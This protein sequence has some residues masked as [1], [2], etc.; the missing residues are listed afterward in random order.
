MK[1]LIF[2]F[3]LTLISVITKAQ[4]DQEGIK[5]SINQF[6][7]GMRNTDSTL[8]KAVIHENCT[9]RSVAKNKEGETVINEEKIQG[10][11]KSVGTKREG[12]KLDERLTSFD[13]KVDG[14]MGIA[15]TPYRFYVNDTFR[16]CGVNVFS[17]IKTKT[18]WKITAIMDTRRKEGCD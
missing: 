2:C 17:L 14:D 5:A 15:W 9:L 12:I 3:C 1:K 8:I 10:F 18:G 16:H 11:I 7:D 4:S 13:I 6:F